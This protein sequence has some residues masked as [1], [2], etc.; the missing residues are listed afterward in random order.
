M[1]ASNTFPIL[2]DDEVG[3]HVNLNN[4]SGPQETNR[5]IISVLGNDGMVSDMHTRNEEN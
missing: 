2:V 5:D 3:Q 4:T 1:R